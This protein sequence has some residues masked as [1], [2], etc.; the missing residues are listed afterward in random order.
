MKY[1]KF[2]CFSRRNLLSGAGV[3]A[4][5]GATG[6][7]GL[8]R[9]F[10]QTELPVQS[11]KPGQWSW[12]P[13]RATTGPVAVVVSLADQLAFVYRNGLRIGVSTVSS[14]RK[15]Y[16]T[17]TGVF[18]VLRKEKMHHSSAY[19]NAPMPDSQFFFN[20]CALH[21]GGLP[22]YPSSHGCVH[23]PRPFAD[24]LFPITHNGTPVIVTR[25]RSG[26][27]TLAHAGLIMTEN[28]LQTLEKMTGNI[29]A[30]GLPTD[31]K[32]KNPNAF[33][34]LISAADEK[35]YGVLN[36]DIILEEPVSIQNDRWPVGT[37]VF[38][39]H[40]INENGQHYNWVA[41]GLGSGHESRVDEQKE[42]AATQRIRMSNRAYQ[43][44]AEYV[45]AGST[46]MLTDLPAHP[47]TRT[48]LD[49]VIMRDAK[50]S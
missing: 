6:M 49:F 20:G 28:D 1:R 31:Q 24:L 38:I 18:T 25:E 12:F 50:V 10:A 43:L 16:E 37:H 35:V 5:A 8:S 27:G 7:T 42:V 2:V 29:R 32:G 14:G 19:N 45:H 44:I 21:A 30:K 17:P 4:L 36:G 11:L 15:G 13:E 3:I 9:V 33:S 22:G 26:V 39:L 40:G 41:V 46:Y 23:L 34:I 47:S 48:S